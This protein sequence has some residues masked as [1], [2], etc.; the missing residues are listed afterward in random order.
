[1]QEEGNEPK[2]AK[3]NDSDRDSDKDSENSD[4]EKSDSPQS[5]IVQFQTAEVLLSPKFYY[6]NSWR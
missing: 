3:K 5:I 1:M 2:R 6:T 4:E